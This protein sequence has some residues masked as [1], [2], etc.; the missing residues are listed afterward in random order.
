MTEFQNIALFEVR[1]RS[2][3]RFNQLYVIPLF[4][5]KIFS[6]FIVHITKRRLY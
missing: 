3:T 4:K 1:R 2:L 6:L 5:K